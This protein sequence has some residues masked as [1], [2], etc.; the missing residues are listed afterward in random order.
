MADIISLGAVRIAR[1]NDHG[2]DDLS[3]GVRVAFEEEVRSV[4]RLGTLCGDP[5]A[6]FLTEELRRVRATLETSAAQWQPRTP[7]PQPRR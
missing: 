4:L 7:A 2:V 1:L 3:D 5:T 6:L